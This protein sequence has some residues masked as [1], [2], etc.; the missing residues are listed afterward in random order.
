[1]NL[2]KRPKKTKQNTT[3]FWVVECTNRIPKVS[4]LT[5][6]RECFKCACRHNASKFHLNSTNPN[7]TLTETNN[8]V[9]E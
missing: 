1:M 2:K 3:G 7:T 5:Q 6:F 8:L 9:D 4:K